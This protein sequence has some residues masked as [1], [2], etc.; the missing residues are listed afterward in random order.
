MFDNYVIYH[1]AD[2]LRLPQS[3]SVYFYIPYRILLTHMKIDILDILK[4]INLLYRRAIA[5]KFSPVIYIK[6]K[7]KAMVLFFLFICGF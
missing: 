5:L 2:F 4:C 6:S 7:N 1:I 3:K